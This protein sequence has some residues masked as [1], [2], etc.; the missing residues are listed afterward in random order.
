[1]MFEKIDHF[2]NLLP[3]ITKEESDF[4]SAIMEWDD[5]T[6]MAFK[7]AKQTFEK[8]LPPA[9]KRRPRASTRG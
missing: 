2:M 3:T 7:F 5:E 4:I 1:M 8:E 9:K 6:K